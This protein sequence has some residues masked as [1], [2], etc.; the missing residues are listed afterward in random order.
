MRIDT[1]IIS[2]TIQRVDNHGDN[3]PTAITDI[4]IID[5]LTIISDT[6][7]F[8]IHMISAN[9]SA[10][11]LD[12]TTHGQISFHVPNDDMINVMI[13]NAGVMTIY[14]FTF[15]KPV[16][17]FTLH[18][19]ESTLLEEKYAKLQTIIDNAYSFDLN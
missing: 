7:N 15:D 13:N 14:T 18:D 6:V 5:H 11:D 8:F 17:E 4:R 19:F 12:N 10:F 3:N 16:R 1:H 2:T 9:N